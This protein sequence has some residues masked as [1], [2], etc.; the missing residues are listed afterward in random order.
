MNRIKILAPAKINL[1]LQV[2]SRR[3]DGYHNLISLFQ[4]ISLYD[5]IVI[6]K[7]SKNKIILNGN[8]NCTTEDNLIF[9]AAEWLK[10]SLNISGGFNITCIKNIPTG[11]GLG[12]GSSDAAAALLGIKS[13]LDLKIDNTFLQKGALELGSDVP[14]FLGAS[15]AIA[16]GRG[17]ELIPIGTREDLFILVTDSGFH[18][19]TKEAFSMLDLNYNTMKILSKDSIIAAYLTQ[20]PSLWPFENS[21]SP[22]LYNKHSIFKSIIEKLNL[23]GSEYSSVTGTGSSVFGV[24]CDE[25]LVDNARKVLKQSNILTHKVKMLANSPKPVYN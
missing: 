23:N 21:F 25:N 14:F 18:C 24:F 12:G 13:L 9:K 3:N 2:T 5:E 1:H 16:E 6:E 17:E 7:I 22:Y 8:F 19:S 15:T 20:K 10:K 11:A 4:M